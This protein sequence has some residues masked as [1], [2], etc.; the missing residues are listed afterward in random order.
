MTS[1]TLKERMTAHK[2]KGS[3]FKHFRLTHQKNPE[4]Q[5]LLSSTKILY[6]PQNIQQLATFEA[7]FIRE[8]RP[9][10]NENVSDFTCLSLNIF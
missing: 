5:D 4:V 6:Q 7:L 9:K 8:K 3:I 10:L 2:Y 1:C